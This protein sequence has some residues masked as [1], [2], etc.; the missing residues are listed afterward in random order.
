MKPNSFACGHNAKSRDSQERATGVLPAST[1]L[2]PGD[3][4]RPSRASHHHWRE[5]HTGERR[6]YL[7]QRSGLLYY[8]P[9]V[10]VNSS[11]LV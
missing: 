5:E 11:G 2:A 1:V 3:S 7:F 8:S 10:N 9:A 4:K 6:Q